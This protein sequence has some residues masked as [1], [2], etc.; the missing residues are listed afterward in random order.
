MSVMARLE[1]IAVLQRLVEP[2][3]V[4]VFHHAD[5]AV[6]VKLVEACGRAGLLAIEFTNRGDHAIDVFATLARHCRQTCPDLVLGAGT[7]VDAPT[8][9]L[10]LAQG[11][12]FVVGP[13][14]S[15]SVARL[16]NRRRVAYL[17]G[18][19]TATEIAQAEELGVEIVKLFPCESVGGP[20]FVRAILGPSPRT[21]ILAT[22]IAE[23][24]PA[25][26]AAWF[27]AGIVA[28]GIGRELFRQ[29]LV[30]RRDY[31]ALERRAAELVQWVRAARGP[32]AAPA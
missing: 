27:K 14:F 8:A 2:G 28:V 11:A 25:S 7:I 12:E 18:C 1:R 13:S 31:Q 21:R 6:A 9:A 3:L 22:G 10:Y 20:A 30:E 32:V 24:S 5:P 16:C 19:A 23:V 17:P 26:L 29:E 4:P 15:E